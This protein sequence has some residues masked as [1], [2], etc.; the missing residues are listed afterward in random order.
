MHTKPRTQTNI[1]QKQ[2]QQHKQ[3]TTKKQQHLQKQRKYKHAHNIYKHI[4]NNYKHLQTILQEK[5]KTQTSTNIS[6]RHLQ[7]KNSDKHY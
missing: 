3:S 5:S 6:T 2:Q 1:L 4:E 7:T